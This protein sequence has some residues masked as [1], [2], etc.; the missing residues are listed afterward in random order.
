MLH[1]RTINPDKRAAH[2]AQ[3]TT[4]EVEN[5]SR[6]QGQPSPSGERLHDLFLETH[7]TARRELAEKVVIGSLLGGSRAIRHG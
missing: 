5:A 2:I 3:R 6:L 7:S 4:T 1:Q